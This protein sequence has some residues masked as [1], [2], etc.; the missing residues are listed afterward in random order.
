MSPRW[1]GQGAQQVIRHEEEQGEMCQW[2]SNETLRGHSPP[3]P[4][5]R[6]MLSTAQCGAAAAEPTV[7]PKEWVGLVQEWLCPSRAPALGTS[8]LTNQ[9]YR[10]AAH[11]HGV[12]IT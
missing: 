12:I 4:C 5:I 11:G 7:L 6:E 2:G 1:D 3:I 8:E 10:T 9:L